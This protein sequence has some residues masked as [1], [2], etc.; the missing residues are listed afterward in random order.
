MFAN[1]LMRLLASRKFFVFVVALLVVQALWLVFSYHFPML[2]DEE[3]HF[4]LIQF[5]AHHLSPFISSQPT[6]ADALGEITR[7]PAWG[8]HWLMSFPYRLITVFTHDQTIQVIILRLINV[9]LFASALVAFRAALIRLTKSRALTHFILLLL[10]LFPLSSLLAAQINYDNLQFLLTGIIFYW[11]LGFIQSKKFDAKLLLLVV[12]VGLLA[13]IVKYTF[14]PLF[15]ALV[16]YLAIFIIRRDGKKS[17][18][19]ASKSFKSLGLASRLALII[20]VLLG[21]GL[22]GE[23]YG[24]N[25]VKYHAVDPKCDKILNVERC[26]SY[27]PYA[28]NYTY[29]QMPKPPKLDGPLK[30]VFSEWL[31]RLYR[32]YFS[33]GTRLSYANYTIKDPMPIPYY[34]FLVVL[35]LAVICL[36]LASRKLIKKPEI[37]LLTLAMVALAIALWYIN[38]PG[39]LKNYQPVAVQGRYLLPMVPFG[40]ALGALAAKT[41]IKSRRA[42]ALIASAAIVVLV[43]G[44]GLITDLVRAEPEWYWPNSTARRANEG[45]Q[46]ALKFLAL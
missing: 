37:Q 22:C 34:G 1:K 40:L 39:Y 15:A 19:L 42:L 11:A 21:L 38:Y 3:Y 26:Q 33:T 4:G 17:L 23:R 2:W 36:V 43:L 8:Y 7:Y 29:Q 9:A 32:Q 30:F 25:L 14:L 31:P 10:V 12:G 44:G 35:A 46:T 24:I 13:C 27:S 16:V 28:R 5:Y 6:S 45:A 20:L 18:E 41:V